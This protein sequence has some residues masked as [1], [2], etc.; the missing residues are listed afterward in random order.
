MRMAGGGRPRRRAAGGE[1]GGAL[2]IP[3]STTARHD[4]HVSAIFRKRFPR[5]AR[6]LIR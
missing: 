3:N 1:E 2:R 6:R 5:Q 4:L